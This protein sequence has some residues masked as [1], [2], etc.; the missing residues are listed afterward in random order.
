MRPL[1]SLAFVFACAGTAL[2]CAN[3]S[4][5][6]LDDL[7]VRGA[8]S[9]SDQPAFLLISRMF[10]HHSQAYW[11]TLERESRERVGRSDDGSLGA[12][13][14]L[15]VAVLKQGRFAEARELLLALDHAEP[16]RYRTLSN[17]GVL[18]KKAG[19][20][21][22][23]AAYLE[24]AL[25]VQPGGHMGLGD[26]Y[27]RACRWQAR[28]SRATPTEDFL[29]R[30][31]GTPRES[32]EGVDR[33]FLKTLIHNDRDFPDV[34]LVYGDLLSAEG[35]AL[36]AGYAY[37]QALRL[38][39]PAPD[40]LDGRLAAVR[41]EFAERTRRSVVARRE[42]KERATGDLPD[43]TDL[44]EVIDAR[45]L[46]RRLD[47]WLT[48][49]EEWSTAFE[50]RQERLLAQ[51]TAAAG[52]SSVSEGFGYAQLGANVLLH[53]LVIYQPG[54]NAD[55]WRGSSLWLLGLGS[56]ALALLA[57]LTGRRVRLRR[58]ASQNA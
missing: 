21:E 35:E 28:A 57:L 9:S 39:H 5:T 24:R 4:Q 1:R 51:G 41:E 16:G 29:G 32:W 11:A 7:A 54:K 30:P 38:G 55:W 58:R 56:L 6:E 10:P 31:Y 34:Y 44:P 33:T 52:L 49:A 19:R 43:L 40:V 22:L 15:A 46:A 26:Y 13:D 17:L 27:L 8:L 50:R 53:D 37:A 45:D 25:A 47:Y 20:Y 48:R 42:G 2:A 14:D 12:R 23:G 18:E 3:Y 36:L